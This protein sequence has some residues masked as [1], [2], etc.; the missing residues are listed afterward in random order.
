MKL[1]IEDVARLS[2]F[3]RV[4]VC[5]VLAGSDKVKETTRNAILNVI[6]ENHYSPHSLSANLTNRKQV[7]LIVGD[8]V[9]WESSFQL[10][11]P[12]IIKQIVQRMYQEGYSCLLYN[13]EYSAQREDEYLQRCV[14]DEIAGVFMLSATGTFSCLQKTT[15]QLP[16]VTINRHVNIPFADSVLLDEYKCAYLAVKHLYDL[17]HRKIGLIT[18][19]KDIPLTLQTVRGFLDISEQ[20][21]LQVEKQ[22]LMQCQVT[23]EDGFKLG[24]KLLQEN[25][26]LTG[27]FCTSY[28]IAT[29]V[30]AAYEQMGRS[31]PGDL[32]IVVFQ[33]I[34]EQVKKN[35]SNFTS[36]GVYNLEDIANAAADIMIQRLS[37]KGKR[38]SRKTR[39]VIDTAIIEGE[40]TAPPTMI[41][42]AR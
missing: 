12:R 21:G 16:V 33:Y 31:V 19:P 38:S 25:S 17:G 6:R 2:G 13:S 18:E 36:V 1:T 20:F 23:F 14:E 41:S 7:A 27:I 15:G 9:D 37:E 4:T 39:L 40:S 42:A 22:D 32:S 8:I 3:S 10:F 26:P 24:Q 29:G 11:H 28:D 5:R 34:S 35:K 30:K